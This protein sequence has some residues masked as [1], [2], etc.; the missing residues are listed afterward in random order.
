MSPARRRVVVAG[1]VL[2]ALLVAAFALGAAGGWRDQVHPV[3]Q[4][5][6]G[7][8]L[9]VPGYGG[10]TTALE[11]LAAS[12][13]DAGREAVVVPAVDGGLGDLHDQARALADSAAQ[14]LTASDAGSVDVVGYSAGGVVVRLWVGE[15]GGGSVVR[16]AVTLASPHHGT[17]V[18]AI[19]GDLAPD[20]CPEACQQLAT[21]SELMRELDAGDETPAGPLWVSIWTTDDQVVVPPESARLEGAVDIPVQSVCPAERVAHADVPANATVIAMTLLELGTEPPRVPGPGVCAAGP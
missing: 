11:A 7:P 17:D 4:S 16:R 1:A 13:R 6:P 5:E 14:V 3:P 18:A 19:G 8:V 10:S 12:L 2:A 21:G 20:S 15:E 9:L